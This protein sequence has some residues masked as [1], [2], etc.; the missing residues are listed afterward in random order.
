[1]EK[2]LYYAVSRRGQ[3][4]IYTEP[5]VRNENF[6][7]YQGRIEGCYSS[8][9]ADFEAE[10]FALPDISWKDEPVKLRLSIEYG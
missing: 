5:P 1:M 7:V 8:L 2:V 6:G 4:C 10:G 3:G 9:V